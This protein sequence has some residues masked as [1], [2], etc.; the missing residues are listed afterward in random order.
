MDTHFDLFVFTIAQ[1]E[2]GARKKIFA[3]INLFKKL[4]FRVFSP[5]PKPNLLVLATVVDHTI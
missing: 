3:K 2:A 4:I 1:K 5:L